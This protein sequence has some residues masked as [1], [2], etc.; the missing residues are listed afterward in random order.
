MFKKILCPIDGSDHSRKALALA[1]DLAKTNGAKLVLMHGLLTNT[2]SSEL[3]H[4]AEVEGLAEKIEPEVTRL[5]A[6]ENR[7]EFSVNEQPASIR[8]LTEIGE[9]LLDGA[10]R[11]AERKGVQD[12]GTFLVGGDIAAQILR[13]ID[14]QN[15]DCVV[16]GARG[17]S[18]V[19][20]LFLGSVSHKVTNRAPCTCITVK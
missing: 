7:P 16:M 20:A 11:E 14:E 18:D 17:L 13:C 10:K 9:H 2:N 5:L 19:K 1:I 15:V 4:F 12:V 3:R 6:V 8:M